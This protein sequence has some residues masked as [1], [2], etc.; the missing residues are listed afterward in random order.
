MNTDIRQHYFALE[1]LAVRLR[2][3]KD[4]SDAFAGFQPDDALEKNALGSLYQ[5]THGV[6]TKGVLMALHV[7]HYR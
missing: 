2:E 6:R 5:P 4:G 3:N 1:S 7:G